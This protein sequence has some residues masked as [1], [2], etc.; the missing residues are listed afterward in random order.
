LDKVLVA[1]PGVVLTAYDETAAVLE[2][3]GVAWTGER[4]V[5]VAP[6]HELAGLRASA[7]LV[8]AHGGFILPGLVN[9]HHHCYSTLARGLDPGVAMSSFGEVLECLWWRLDRALDPATVRLSAA[10]SLADCIR[11][12]CTTVFDHH[13]SPSCLE[14]SLDLVAGEVSRAGLSA[15]L[16]YE[17]SDRNSHREALLGLEEN[18]RFAAAH[19]SDPRVRGLLGLHASFTVTDATLEKAA[20]ARPQDLGI[21]VHVCEDPIDGLRSLDSFGAR[22][23]ER[24]GHFGLLD[25]NAVLAHGIHLDPE[26]YA[27]IAE[28]GATLVHNPESNNNN[29]VGRLDLLEAASAGA[30]L[31]LGTD[32]M[33]CNMLRAL[34]TA[35]LTLRAGT[36]DPRTGFDVVPGLL[37]TNARVAAG[38]FEEPL[39]GRLEPGAPADLL[40]VDRAPPT[41]ATRDNW[42]AHLVYGGS[43]GSVRHT[44]ARGA[45]LL[46][47]FRHT[48]LPVDDLGREARRR[49]PELWRRFRA[50]ASEERS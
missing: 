28:S 1:G 32:G 14:G 13:A 10:L 41:P 49:S 46:Q 22:P 6:W 4:I 5:A 7:T 44:V 15:V 39:L 34:R 42:F 9:L 35:F 50:L 23:I 37:G 45:I 12:G 48:T 47:D 19:S 2:D 30:K 38:L 21:H 31:A 40:V 26:E 25:R 17:V 36:G 24:F 3:A 8:D 16:C 33:S 18:F 43:E 20:E 11:W 29:A 27:S